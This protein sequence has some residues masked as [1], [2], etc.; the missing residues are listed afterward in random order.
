MTARKEYRELATREYWDKYYAA[1]K[2]SNEKGHEWFRTYE[3]LKPFFAHNLFNRE[4]LQVKDNPMIL[5]PGSGESVCVSCFP[6]NC[7]QVL[8]GSLRRTSPYG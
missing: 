4:G 2:K 1:A 5:H 7:F 3:Q 6:N 8:I